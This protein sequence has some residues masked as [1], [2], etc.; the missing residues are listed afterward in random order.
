LQQIIG[1]LANW[2]IGKLAHCHIILLA[3]YYHMKQALTY[4]EKE[5]KALYP[6]TE[7]KSFYYLIVEKLTSLSRTEI[8]ANKNT[9]FSEQQQQLL[10]A[11][12]TRLKNF[13][14]IQYILGE[15]EFYGLPFL[16]NEAVLIPR[17]ETEELV[18]WIQKENDKNATADMLDIGTGSGC[19]AIALKSEFPNARVTAF[20]ISERALQIAQANALKNRQSVTFS[21]VDILREHSFTANWD[22]IV[23]NPPYIPEQEKV[24]ISP[25]VLNHEPHLALFVPNEDPLL[26]YRTIALFAKA[27]LRPK[28]KLYFEIH[29]DAGQSCMDMLALLGFEKL[30]LRTD[31]AGNDRMIRAEFVSPQ[32]YVESKQVDK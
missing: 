12:I 1:K 7:I 4:M 30:E 8:I 13:E 28:G 15:T 11:F 10:L 23:S 32:K 24:E 22:L 17:P 3:Y 26:F 14:P 31:I 27:R 19:I 21:K 16:V 6:Q 29:R 5:L 9:V 18:E 20:D 25:N 2:Q